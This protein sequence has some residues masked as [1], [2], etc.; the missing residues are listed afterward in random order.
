MVKQFG[1]PGARLTR[2]NRLAQ[3]L[4]QQEQNAPPITAHSQGLASLLRNFMIGQSQ[5]GDIRDFEAAQAAMA[6]PRGEQP[7]PLPYGVQGPPQASVDPFAA[8]SEAVGALEGGYKRQALAQLGEQREEYQAGQRTRAQQ[9]QDFANQRT[10]GM[11][12]YE[13]QL[14][15]KQQYADPKA[16]KTIK[17]AEGV[18]ILNADGTLGN[19]LG[20]SAADTVINLAGE[21]SKDWMRTP[22]GGAMPIPGGKA[23][24]VVIQEAEEAK[25][26]AALEIKREEDM[27]GIRSGIMTKTD[28]L[29]ILKNNIE[30]IKKLSAG[31]FTS[32][33]VGQAL[34]PFASSDQY[35]LE[36]KLETI[37]SAVG[38]Q[39]LIDVKAQ[40][41]T[42][43]SLTENE[44]SLLISAVGALDANL[45]PETLG[46]VLDNVVRLYEKGLNSAKANF[47][48]KYPDARR[49]WEVPLPGNTSGTTIGPL[50]PLPNFVGD[51]PP[52]GISEEDIQETMRANNMTREQVIQRLSGQ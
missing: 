14:R 42:F 37:K 27:P 8:R 30:D 43:G 17:T 41:A 24:P 38:L 3:Q 26:S 36:A 15:L 28:R 9:L 52:G 31:M 7:A 6:T 20:G 4:M 23:D 47:A 33:V 16:V 21:L 40:G 22:Q 45:G 50:E 13:T 51:E 12:D 1:T 29:P 32:G 48:E 2:K 35:E 49:P 10:Q 18:Y 25:K 46:P 19:R 34:S 11:E 39:E 44:M 5:R